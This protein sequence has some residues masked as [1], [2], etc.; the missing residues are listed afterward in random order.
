[1]A[2]RPLDHGAKQ[3]G[4]LLFSLLLVTMACVL[5]HQLIHISGVSM[6]PNYPDGSKMWIEET[7]PQDLGRG[8][9]VYFELWLSGRHFVKRL[10]GLPGETIR[11][12]PEGV[13]VDGRLLEET[14]EVIPYKKIDETFSLGN[15]EYFVLGDNRPNSADSQNCGPISGSAILGR[16]VPID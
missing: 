1:M 3:L 12:A 16:A 5:G 9:L 11:L 13:Y 10:V 8:D 15:D 6:E 2:G 7:E 14:Y 4:L